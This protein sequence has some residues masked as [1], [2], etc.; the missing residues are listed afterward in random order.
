VNAA[1]EARNREPSMRSTVPDD[2]RLVAA[3]KRGDERA[4]TLLVDRYHASLVR[5][6]ALYVRDRAVAEEVAQETWL[7]VLR[8]IDRFEGRSSL[9]TWIFRILTNT[10]KTRGE[11]EGRTV[12]FSALA[13]LDEPEAAVDP[14]RFLDENHPQWPGHWAEYP[15][16]WESAPERRL[17]SKETLGRIKEA[18]DELPPL[19]GQVIA[20]R[21]VEGWG[22]DE[23]CELLG[24]SEGNQRVLLHRARSRLRR[25]LED[26]LADA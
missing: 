7:G 13:G 23:V 10:A 24:I 15:A 8:G 3:I 2:S 1:A 21:D 16:S 20:L 22:S 12:P 18:I 19:Q 11:R 6:A 17:H 5:L 14:E 25:A 26:Y 4:F 9:K